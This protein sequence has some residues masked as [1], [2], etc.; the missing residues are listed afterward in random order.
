MNGNLNQPITL[1]P[2]R[3]RLYR[4]KCDSHP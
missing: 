2:F 3:S 1:P 4:N